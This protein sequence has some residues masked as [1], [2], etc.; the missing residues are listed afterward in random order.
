MKV[1]AGTQD[2]LF[3]EAMRHALSY[4]A[5][6]DREAKARFLETSEQEF[7]AGMSEVRADAQ[8]IPDFHLRANVNRP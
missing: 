1:I 6:G 8:S 5:T 7:G 3:D 2:A 4:I